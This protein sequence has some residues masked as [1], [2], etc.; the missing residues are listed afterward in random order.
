MSEKMTI[1][2]DVETGALQARS[3]SGL[4]NIDD[5]PENYVDLQYNEHRNPEYIRVTARNHHPDKAIHAFFYTL[6][7]KGGHFIPGGKP[8]GTI[9]T[10]L[11]PSETTVIHFDEKKHNFRLFL[12]NAFFEN[13]D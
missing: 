6:H 8:E 1:R 12:F 5:S 7:E 3:I 9:K 13:G 4:E 11:K 10:C 2:V